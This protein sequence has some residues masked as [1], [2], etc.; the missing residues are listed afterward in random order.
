MGL[1]I[2]TVGGSGSG[3]TTL[4]QALAQ[5]MGFQHFDTD[6]YYWQKTDPPF[7][8]KVPISDRIKN[9]KKDLNA[10][11]SWVL[12]GSLV[13]W[14]SEIAELFTSV[15]FI[16]IPSEVRMKRL[17]ER[18]RIRHGDRIKPG[19]DMHQTHQEFL[20]W[21]AQYDDVNFNGRSRVLH[22]Q[23]LQK[24]NC[25]IVRIENEMSVEEEVRYVLQN[26]FEPKLHGC[27]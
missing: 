22:E 23:W 8:H 7:T 1:K 11:D 27:T 16:C 2:H 15:V 4:A 19:G 24:L 13:S 26:Q 3:T 21:A 14:G 5:Q 18:E 12:S 17:E 10:Q 20:V 9:L 6:H 25:P